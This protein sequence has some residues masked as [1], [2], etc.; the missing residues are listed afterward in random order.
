MIRHRAVR[1]RMMPVCNATTVLLISR[2][3]MSGAGMVGQ[4]LSLS[5]GIRCVARED[6]LATVNTYGD[7]ATRIAA[8]VAR[9]E[10]A[11]QEF[12]EIRRPYLILM[13]RALLEHARRGRLAYFGYS[14]H[15]LV[16]HIRH[17][18]RI[19]LIAPMATRIARARESLGCSEAEARDH[20]RRVDQ[21]RAHWSRVMYG[22][23]LRDPAG[24]DISLNL[25]RLSLEGACD[26][27][28][29]AIEQTDFQ[30]TPDSV[31][32]VENEYLAAQVLAALTADPATLN[33]DLGA[34]AS[35]GVVR[36]V[37]PHLSETEKSMA[38]AVAGAVPDVREAVYEA[39]YAPA[40]HYA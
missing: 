3:T 18:V 21:E 5:E 30:P 25:E 22:V 23:D 1:V 26:L 12:S 13:R 36:L 9:A 10:Q 11:Y 24:Y 40:F 34:S 14:G 6:L 28:R 16:P 37:G 27:L 33:L 39:G 4:C 19:R 32:Q 20:I 8:R 35:A 29:R 7:L 38:L 2:G 17:F 31:E 15:L